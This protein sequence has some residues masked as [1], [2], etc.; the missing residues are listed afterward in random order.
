MSDYHRFQTNYYIGPKQL[1]PAMD[2]RIR[3]KLDILRSKLEAL[4]NEKNALQK[5]LQYYQAENRE[6]REKLAGGKE[7]VKNFPERSENLNIAGENGQN[8]RK[9]AAM[10]K[11]IEAYVQE[12]DW[13]IAQMEN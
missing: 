7:P 9:I 1:K 11:E 10:S 5:D 6:L 3:E 8:T 13:C 4:I 12:I 2:I